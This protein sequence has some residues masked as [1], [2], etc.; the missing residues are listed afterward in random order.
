MEEKGRETQ[1][2][3]KL[4][5]Q[6]SKTKKGGGGYCQ[7]CLFLNERDVL[8]QRVTQSRSRSLLVGPFGTQA[9]QR[10]WSSSFFPLI[11]P[12]SVTGTNSRDSL[13]S[14]NSSTEEPL[15]SGNLGG[16]PL[17]GHLISVV[18]LQLCLLIIWKVRTQSLSKNLIPQMKYP[19]PQHH[20]RCC[21]HGLAM[22]GSGGRSSLTGSLTQR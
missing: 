3:E 12:D 16:M 13:K 19:D 18:S 20:T 14:A 7:E 9:P 8:C 1:H 15:C 5:E 10:P 11:R 4:R 6:K 17:Q 22:G 2:L 21:D